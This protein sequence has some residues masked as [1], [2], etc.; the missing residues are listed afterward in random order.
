[1]LFAQF[2]FFFCLKLLAYF[3]FVHKGKLWFLGWGR[4]SCREYFII[5]RPFADFIKNYLIWVFIFRLIWFLNQAFAQFIYLTGIFGII[6]RCNLSLLIIIIF[7]FFICD[8]LNNLPG[9][10]LVDFV[11]ISLQESNLLATIYSTPWHYIISVIVRMSILIKGAMH[12]RMAPSTL[13][14]GQSPLLLKRKLINNQEE[15]FHIWYNTAFKDYEDY[16]FT[17]DQ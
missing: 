11:S 4:R 16:Y 12:E 13:T 10:C 5:I 14:P 1:M 3:W 6:L 2:L 9:I 17:V 7:I 15:S 8:S